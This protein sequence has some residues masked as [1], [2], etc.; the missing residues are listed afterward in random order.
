[1]HGIERANGFH[2]E[3]AADSRK[4]CVSDTDEVATTREYL[5]SPYRGA[6]ISL[7]Q[8]PGGA[9]AKDG[10]GSFG[11]CQRGRDPPPLRADRRP[12]CHVTLQ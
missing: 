8:P 9:P 7:T 10:A 1:M 2:R 11:E 6:F 12:G 5:E 4:N 3:G